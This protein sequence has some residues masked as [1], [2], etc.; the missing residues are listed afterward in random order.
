M[1]RT[2]ILLTKGFAFII[3]E[4]EDVAN[5]V[6]KIG[7]HIILKRRVEVVK[8]SPLNTILF[9]KLSDEIAKLDIKNI[10]KRVMVA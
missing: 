9:N 8:F 3:F 4:S 10:P 1:T 6:V 7:H 5:H 2:I